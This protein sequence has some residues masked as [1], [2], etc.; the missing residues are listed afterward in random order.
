MFGKKGKGTS[1]NGQLKVKNKEDSQCPQTDS[2]LAGVL[3]KFFTVTKK[4]NRTVKT[5]LMRLR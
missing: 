1:A 2:I 3:T 4:E 5:K